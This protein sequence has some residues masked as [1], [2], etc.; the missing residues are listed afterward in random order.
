MESIEITK[1]KSICCKAF[2]HYKH[3]EKENF[4]SRTPYCSNCGEFPKASLSAL[5]KAL[6]I[7]LIKKD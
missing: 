3:I 1:Q 7:L 2:I 4:K 5:K 6:K